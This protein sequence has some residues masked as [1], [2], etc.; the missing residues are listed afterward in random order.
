MLMSRVERGS[1]PLTSDRMGTSDGAFK[2]RPREAYIDA[3]WRRCVEEYRLDPEVLPAQEYIGGP[4]LKH[5][6]ESM[7]LFERVGRGEMRRLFDEIQQHAQFS[8]ADS[9]FVLMLAD[10]DATIMEVFSDTSDTATV[11]FIQASNMRPGFIWDERHAGANGPGTCVH[12]RLP[13]LV[14]REDHFFSCNRNMSCSAGPVWGSNGSLLGAV[15]LSFLDCR[16]NRSSQVVTGTLV[17]MSARIIEHLHFTQQYRDF[18]VMHFHDRPESTGLTYDSLLAIDDNGRVLAVDRT[19]PGRF[20]FSSHAEL[21]GRSVADLFDISVERLFAQAESQP[22]AIWPIAFGQNSHGYA[23]LHPARNTSTG[24]TRA[25][26]GRSQSE[27]GARQ[28]S[29]QPTHAGQ[30]EL[31]RAAPSIEAIAGNDPA[32]R[33]NVWRAEHVMNKDIHMLLLGETGTGKDTFA[34]AIHRA[35]DRRNEPFIVISC[36]AIPEALIESELFGYEPGAFTGARAGG[37]R[38]KALAAHRGTLF[39]DEIGDMPLAVQARLLRL[40]EEKEVTPLGRSTAIPVDIRVISATN[41]DLECLMAR[42]EF[43]AD[44]FYRLNGMPLTMPALRSRVDRVMLIERVAQEENG[45]VPIEISPDAKA[46][47]LAYNWPGNIRELR[48]ALRSATVFAENRPLEASHLPGAVVRGAGVRS[49]AM[50]GADN[51]LPCRTEEEC[52][53]AANPAEHAQI[54]AELERQHWR[55]TSTASALGIS[56]NTLY[57]KLHR[58]GLLPA[59]AATEKN[60]VQGS[61]DAGQ[62]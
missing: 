17:N 59:I 8:L 13:R 44:L 4:A 48:S 1:P 38:G 43:R 30:P 26:S 19:V 14:H 37:M 29:P 60:I 12:D 10:A 7:A 3:A 56:R 24:T 20:G 58:Y 6:R 40:L 32:M 31:P 34:R 47:L 18:L 53:D 5:R 33:E 41:K 16:E 39:L 28:R 61:T 42:G 23:S 57:R 25:G 52:S 50:S 55:I 15:D 36:A 22:F 51:A 62:P 45:G 49:A 11:E 9:R 54:L 46:I 27:R 35:S 21:V 2:P